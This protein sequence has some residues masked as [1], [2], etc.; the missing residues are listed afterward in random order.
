MSFEQC[1]SEL[2]DFLSK[3][4]ANLLKIVNL[5]CYIIY[6]YEHIKSIY[7]NMVNYAKYENLDLQKLPNQVSNNTDR[8]TK[9]WNIKMAKIS[10]SVLIIFIPDIEFKNACESL[11]QLVEVNF[12]ITLDCDSSIISFITQRYDSIKTMKN[13][14]IY[15]DIEQKANEIMKSAKQRVIKKSIISN[16]VFFWQRS[17]KIL[18]KSVA[19]YL[20]AWWDELMT[21]NEIVENNEILHLLF[22]YHNKVSQDRFIIAQQK[23]IYL[24]CPQHLFSNCCG[25]FNFGDIIQLAYL[26]ENN[27][28]KLCNCNCPLESHRFSNL[29]IYKEPQIEFKKVQAYFKDSQSMFA[30]EAFIN[31]H[32]NSDNEIK[33]LKND[34]KFYVDGE[35]VKNPNQERILC[36]QGDLKKV[37]LGSA[38]VVV[39]IGEEASGKTSLIQV[40][41]NAIYNLPL[42][43]GIVESK[44]PR[45]ISSSSSDPVL[46]YCSRECSKDI[47]FIECQGLAALVNN[48]DTQTINS[49][50]SSM[51]DLKEISMIIIVHKSDTK[52]LNPSL[53]Q[54]KYQI[55]IEIPHAKKA[56]KAYA[57][58]FYSGTL[59][60]HKK[61]NDSFD[62]NIKIDN[63]SPSNG[64]KK[65]FK[66]KLL[67]NLNKVKRIINFLDDEEYKKEDLVVQ[68][69][70][71]DILL[72]TFSKCNVYTY[73]YIILDKVNMINRNTFVACFTVPKSNESSLDLS[74]FVNYFEQEACK[75]CGKNKNA[76]IISDR[77]YTPIEVSI[78]SFLKDCLERKK[79]FSALLYDK[80]INNLS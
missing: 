22:S 38:Q 68:N 36:Y 65:K 13:I 54:V 25:E 66:E 67:K 8:I 52:F 75:A 16:S 34:V 4:Q 30:K 43:M 64:T 44:I 61:L 41:M 45:N 7:E 23:T 37:N 40:C 55:D 14:F 21:S 56:K 69:F 74:L 47:A 71:V 28:K 32:R 70:V 58:T 20:K 11:D 35:I 48:L 17:V 19:K 5:K 1:F 3:N 24:Y 76:H 10:A 73:N 31:L 33:D 59:I 27:S 78:V 62:F 46:Y 53:E 50:I 6:K 49:V 39:V 77:L 12:I 57:F 15:Q 26:R 63:I 18:K 42:E 72:N 80:I 29:S 51:K 60:Y 2:N 79:H 9:L